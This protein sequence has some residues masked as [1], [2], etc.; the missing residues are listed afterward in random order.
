MHRILSP[1]IDSPPFQLFS[2]LYVVVSSPATAA[3][4]GSSSGLA[5]L[6]SSDRSVTVTERGASTSLSSWPTLQRES[7]ASCTPPGAGA[8][9]VYVS[10]LGRQCSELWAWSV[11]AG[12]TRCGDMVVGRSRHGACYVGG[13]AYAIGGIHRGATVDS[14]EFYDPVGAVSLCEWRDVF[15]LLL[16]CCPVLC[17]GWRLTFVFVPCEDVIHPLIP[18]SCFIINY[19][20]YCSLCR[21]EQVNARLDTLTQNL[22]S[23]ILLQSDRLAYAN[24]CHDENWNMF[25]NSELLRTLTYS[26]VLDAFKTLFCRTLFVTTNFI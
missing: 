22:Y 5:S 24:C 18:I 13:R 11:A 4:T 20:F 16:Y 23:N 14:I 21:L 2:S 12:W 9:V 10:G 3:G 17:A 7:T 25:R 15:L 6:S 26:A 8:T 1:L 19:E